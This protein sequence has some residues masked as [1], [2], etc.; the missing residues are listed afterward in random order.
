MSSTS[1]KPKTL[2]KT[3]RQEF[4]SKH[5]KEKKPKLPDKISPIKGIPVHVHAVD[6][7]SNGEARTT[8]A[9]KT[10]HLQAKIANNKPGTKVGNGKGLILKHLAHLSGP[11]V[12]FGLNIKLSWS[13]DH[14]GQRPSLNVET[15]SLRGRLKIGN[16]QLAQV[17]RVY[18][19][20]DKKVLAAGWDRSWN[21]GKGE[22][23]DGEAFG[24]GPLAQ[25]FRADANLALPSTL[26][27]ATTG[28]FFVCDLD[29]EF[30][31]AQLQTKMGNAFL[32]TGPK[33]EFGGS[34]TS[35]RGDVAPASSREETTRKKKSHVSLFGAELKGVKIKR[36]PLVNKK[37]SALGLDS[38]KAKHLGIVAATQAKKEVK[39]DAPDL[40]AL[41]N[42]QF[43]PPS[44][45]GWKNLKPGKVLDFFEKLE[46]KEGVSL[47]GELSMGELSDVIVIPFYQPSEQKHHHHRSP[48]KDGVSGEAD[49][50]NAG[51]PPEVEISG[52]AEEA[53]HAVTP[54]VESVGSAE[55]GGLPKAD[56]KSGSESTV[57]WT[58]LQA[59]VAVFDFVRIGTQVQEKEG[60]P[61]ITLRLDVSAKVAGMKAKF[62][63]LGARFDTDGRSSGT[64]GFVDHFSMVLQGI[65]IGFHK[66]GV[67]VG[68]GLLRTKEKVNRNGK[69]ETVVVYTGDAVLRAEEYGFSGVGSFSKGKHASLFLFVFLDAP[70]GTPTIHVEQMAAGFGY[71]RGAESPDVSELHKYPLI[72]TMV[73]GEVD[74][75][76]Y[77]NNFPPKPGNVWFGAGV[78]FSSWEMI[79][80]S[81]IPLLSVGTQSAV[82]IV[83]TAS[84]LIPKGRNPPVEIALALEASF[85][86][87]TG[88]LSFG[89]ELLPKTRI[90][91]RE[92]EFKGGFG[93]C[94]WLPTPL[95]GSK[96][97]KKVGDYV[98]TLGG[99]HPKLKVP[100]YY[101]NVPRIGADVTISKHVSIRGNV[102]AALTPSALMF[103]GTL[104]AVVQYDAFKA[105]FQAKLD[106]IMRWKPLHYD[107]KLHV[108]IS[109]SVTLHFFGT[110]TISAHVGAG[111]HLEGPP[112][113]GTAKIDLSVFSTTIHFGKKPSS[114]KRLSSWGKFREAFLESGKSQAGAIPA[115]SGA[116]LARSPFCSVHVTKGLA[117]RYPKRN[118]KDLNSSN[119]ASRRSE[120]AARTGGSKK[121]KGWII[122]PRTLRLD[123][124]TKVPST[125]VTIQTEGG[126]HSKTYDSSET[127]GNDQLGVAPTIKSD[128]TGGIQ[129]GELQ[130]KLTITVRRASNEGTPD[131]ELIKRFTTNL[132]WR[133]KQVPK[134]MW[135]GRPSELSAGANAHIQDALM[136]VGL[137]A[138]I[139][140]PS[141]TNTFSWKHLVEDDKT[142][143][144]PS[145]PSP[146]KHRAIGHRLDRQSIAKAFQKSGVPDHSMLDALGKSGFEVNPGH[147][148]VQRLDDPEKQGFLATPRKMSWK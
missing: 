38:I 30:L 32:A 112:I 98:L 56:G 104:G 9:Q 127:G 40:S 132:R 31:V 19:D 74:L 92:A 12:S 131:E 88:R 3:I 95:M 147:L 82:N 24:P 83:G 48:K 27:F 59:S 36:L 76:E 136:G 8:E 45:A 94:T 122:H 144:T 53:S 108:N 96:Q 54:I 140:K 11:H 16:D 143:S 116:S 105:S 20:I 133:K 23:A 101:P 137:E 72:K 110:H 49:S 47:I 80:A 42:D 44:T 78:Q 77:K 25:V 75:R 148:S 66:G 26:P 120:D 52:S 142:R 51:P 107:A 86:F 119:G 125:E 50:A 43:N 1:N 22:S 68:A 37:L 138:T 118:P 4:H 134:S 69:K 128:G 139:D 34:T 6:P 71:N 84:I 135:G 21:E 57:H 102:Y 93:I 109:V 7:N 61:K 79:N 91:F 141:E 2:G 67:Q 99:Y 73:N 33:N 15:G 113:H 55:E 97:K 35:D 17:F 85:S 89:G 64:G 115:T 129:P 87:N 90:V 18:Y 145:A 103:G 5:E 111:L 14:T 29:R 126:K 41:D 130:P 10:F 60:K 28:A 124:E 63:G 65:Q 100:S 114:S 117:Q 13:P 123:V 121:Q 106:V 46:V 146:K 70:I 62:Y 81:V 39:F 58:T